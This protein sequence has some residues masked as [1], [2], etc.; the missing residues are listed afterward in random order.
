MDVRRNQQEGMYVYVVN[1]NFEQ[2]LGLWD[3]VMSS[4]KLSI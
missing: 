2:A 3:L 1:K 4:H